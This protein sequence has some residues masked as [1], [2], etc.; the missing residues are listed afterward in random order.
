[1]KRFLLVVAIAGIAQ[2]GFSQ[3]S[4]DPEV[5]ASFSSVR[6]KTGDNSAVNSDFKTGFRAGAGVNIAISNGLYVKPGLFYNMLGGKEK[7]SGTT[8]STTMHYLQVPVNIGYNYTI[9]DK[10]GGV[11]VEAGPY[12][13]IALAGKN[14]I[15]NNLGETKTDIDFGDG[16]T[17]TNAFDW[18]FNFGLGY[19]TP[20]GIYVRGGYGLGLGNLSNV[21]DVTATNQN[22][23]V[24]IGYRIKL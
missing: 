4:I 23:N 14:K 8:A 12:A 21:N 19:E 5:D 16:A 6:T 17:E 15:E 24:G 22:W 11:F 2:T 1:M 18:G 13:G 9:S 20:W 7:T 10:A 3:I